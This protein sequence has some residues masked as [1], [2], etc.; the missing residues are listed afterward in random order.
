MI[1]V[2]YM[3]GSDFL[4]VPVQYKSSGRYNAGV[5]V[6]YDDESKLQYAPFIYATTQSG[7]NGPDE[8]GDEEGEDTM[9]ITYDGANERYD[10]T[11]KEAVDAFNSG[12]TVVI[13][14][15]TNSEDPNSNVT[16]W[17]LVK[18]LPNVAAAPENYKYTLVFWTLGGSAES[19]V[20]NTLQIGC[21]TPADYL[22]NISIG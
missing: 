2:N 14:D 13:K 10:K 1:A 8:G 15:P 5:D 21:A 16:V 6:I 12:K 17:Y 4:K 19:P 20:P 22:T 11:W 3:K 7:D 9:I 18:I